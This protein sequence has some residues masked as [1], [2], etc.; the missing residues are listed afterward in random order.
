MTFKIRMIASIL[1]QDPNSWKVDYLL[2]QK[3]NL[4]MLG[5]IPFVSVQ[6]DT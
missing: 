6:D 4:Q 2:G 5:V 3:H 1:K